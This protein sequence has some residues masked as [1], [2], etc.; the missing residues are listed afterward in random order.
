MISA[1]GSTSSSIPNVGGVGITTQGG[2][3]SSCPT[4]SWTQNVNDKGFIGHHFYTT[5]TCEQQNAKQNLGFTDEDQYD[6]I[7]VFPEQVVGSVRLDRFYNSQ[8][9]DHFYATDDDPADINRAKQDGYI[10]ETNLGINPMYVLTQAGAGFGASFT[11]KCGEIDYTEPSIS[12]IKRLHRFWGVQENDHFYATDDADL[13]RAHNDGYT[14]ED[15]YDS[16]YVP[17]APIQRNNLNGKPITAVRLHRL[18]HN[19]N[20]SS[21]GGVVSSTM[22]TYY[23]CVLQIASGAEP[24]TFPIVSDSYYDALADLYKNHLPGDMAQWLVNPG[25]CDL[26]PGP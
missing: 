22:T 20:I 15:C 4:S 6:S 24:N 16:I 11:A 17:I 25:A 19:D 10:N 9:S 12:N 14:N 21:S 23:F 1:C 18:Y 7:Y 3:P 5:D 13:T 8:T 26:P 2:P